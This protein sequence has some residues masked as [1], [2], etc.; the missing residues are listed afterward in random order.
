M[1]SCFNACRF[2]TTKEK[3]HKFID[4]EY[5]DANGGKASDNENAEV[6]S[7]KEPEAKMLKLDP[8]ESNKGGKP[9]SK[10]LRGQNK[11]RPH[12]KPTTYD[13]NRLCLSVLRV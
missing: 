5:K 10:R 9:D 6:T 12:V 3:F 4:S 2:R 13:D 8:E 11:S 1:S 7:V